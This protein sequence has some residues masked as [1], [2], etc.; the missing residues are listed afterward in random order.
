MFIEILSPNGSGGWGGGLLHQEIMKCP[1]EQGHW[2]HGH[3]WITW[4]VYIVIMQEWLHF[5]SEMCSFP[6]S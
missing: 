4:G 3:S 1:K 5:H 6:V 2:G